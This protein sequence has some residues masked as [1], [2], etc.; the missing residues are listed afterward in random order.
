[1]R[2]EFINSNPAGFDSNCVI[3]GGKHRDAVHI[4]R[5]AQKHDDM[6]ACHLDERQHARTC[7]YWYT[8]TEGAMSH[9]AFATRAGLDRW[10]HERG[11]VFADPMPANREDFWTGKIIGHYYRNCELYSQDDW[12]NLP[13]VLVETWEVNN[14]DYTEAKI[15]RHPDGSM[16]VNLVNCNCK[17]RKVADYSTMRAKM[18]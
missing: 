4:L 5:F 1:M 6:H 10:M 8:V 15:T 9:V 16:I 17:W 7:G 13:G 2:H 3:C 12:A 18:C 11:L 14:G